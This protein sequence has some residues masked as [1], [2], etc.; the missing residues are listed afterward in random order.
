MKTLKLFLMFVLL[1]CFTGYSQVI[2]NTTGK[3]TN[4][5]IQ[6]IS[7]SGFKDIMSFQTLN[8]GNINYVLAQQTGKQ[9]AAT[10]HQQNSA[11]SEMSNQSY[12][13]QSGNSNEMTIGQM[14]S[15]NL[16]LG[17]QLGYLAIMAGSE[18]VNELPVESNTVSALLPSTSNGC[19]MQGNGN[20][21]NISQTGNNNGIMSIQQGD[22]NTFS[23][24]QKGNNNYLMTLQKG[25][26]NL[27]TGYKQENISEGALFE[28]IIQIGDNLSLKTDEF[29]LS[30]TTG[31]T[32][33][34]T[35]SNL[36]LDVN[37]S[38]LNSVGGIEINQTG[39]DMKV[40]V[41]QSYFS[42]PMK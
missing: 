22:N 31:N 30:K 40:V 11:G 8:Q 36:S 21:M 1:S 18:S 13:V 24:V 23:A 33:T 10:I 2:I 28:K 16:L 39:N 14:G 5:A 27:V 12:S 26:N 25:R 34:Q 6:Q 9:N 17:F 4:E 15:G 32:F 19:F 41:D 35:G 37:N 7:T 38:L 3:E 20:K 29:S 42:F